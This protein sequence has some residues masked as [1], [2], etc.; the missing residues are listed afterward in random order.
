MGAEPLLLEGGDG[1]GRTM[2]SPIRVIGAFLPG[3]FRQGLGG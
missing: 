1:R 3:G 2:D